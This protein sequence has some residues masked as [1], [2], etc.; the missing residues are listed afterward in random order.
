M[1]KPSEGIKGM[2]YFNNAVK[3]VVDEGDQIEKL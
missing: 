2:D 3:K 1:F